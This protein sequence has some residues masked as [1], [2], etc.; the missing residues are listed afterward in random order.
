LDGQIRQ[1]SQVMKIK[2]CDKQQSKI[3]GLRIHNKASSCCKVRHGLSLTLRL[4]AA[5]RGLLLVLSSLFQQGHH[6]V[7]W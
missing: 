5:A 2:G 7:G 4:T 6:Q 3:D 1:M